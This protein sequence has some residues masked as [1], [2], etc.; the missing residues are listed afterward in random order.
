MGMIRVRYAPS[1]TGN[2][3]VGNIRTALFTYLFARK[4]KGQF[5]IRIE[6]TDKKREVEKSYTAIYESLKWLGLSWDEPPLKQSDRL[7]I[8]KQHAQKL[9][10]GGAAFEQNGAVYFK[11][12]KEGTTFWT[13]LVGSKLI[14]FQNDTQEDFV[15]LKSNGFPTYHLASVVDDHLM[16]ISHVTRGEDWISSTPKH[17]MIYEAFGWEKPQFA[18][19]PNILATDRSKLSKRHGAIGILDFKK[20]GILAETL[21]NYLALLGWTPHQGKEILTLSEMVEEFDLK[22][23]NIAPAIFDLTKL[24]WMNGEYIRKMSDKELKKRLYEYL[25][26]HPA[27][28]KI[29][30]LIP[31]IKDRIKKLSDF[32]PLTYFFFEKV[33]YE[34]EIFNKLNINNSED[35][36][37]KVLEKLKSMEKPWRSDI[38]ESNF[39]KLAQDLGISATQMFQLI[40]VAISG[41]TVTPPLFESIKI[42]GEDE[43]IKR[44]E[45]A[46]QINE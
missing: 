14:E 24:E 33:D 26:D 32:I 31:L 35:A 7:T 4:N 20:D 36:L 42:L 8:Y 40:R 15:I 10:Q 27:K 9:L 21:I 12:K 41:Q 17:L 6:D 38:F 43:T 5:L 34:K 25:V 2:P 18:H 19:F 13:D 29:A 37:K 30:P 11:I 28:G 44:I 22:D 46:Q 16:E 23:I 3:H 45:Q 1:P 39:R